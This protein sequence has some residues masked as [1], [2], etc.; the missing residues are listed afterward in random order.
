M[1]TIAAAAGNLIVAATAHTATPAQRTAL[2]RE[3]DARDHQPRHQRVVVAGGDQLQQHERAERREPHGAAGVGAERAREPRHE[4]RR[5]ARARS[6]RAAARAAR[7]RPGATRSRRR[8]RLTIPRNSGP[9]GA[10]VWRQNGDTASSR[11]AWPCAA[12]TTRRVAIGVEPQVEELALR[13]GSC[14]TSRLNSAGPSSDRRCTTAAPIA[15][16]APDARQPPPEAEPRHAHQRDPGVEQSARRR[17]WR[18]R[19][20]TSE[21][22]RRA[23]SGRSARPAPNPRS[24]APAQQA[25]RRIRRCPPPAPAGR[26]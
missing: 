12:S 22:R 6:G 16:S 8:T 17:R 26:R 23:A 2:D 13:R 3:R 9:Y 11:C 21:R 24:R 14:T 7:R 18:D 1:N 15:H 10:V 19:T 5:A 4:H 25:E 20:T